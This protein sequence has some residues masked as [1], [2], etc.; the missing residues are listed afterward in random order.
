[1]ISAHYLKDS[2]KMAYLIEQKRRATGLFLAYCPFFVSFL[3][4]RLIRCQFQGDFIN[5]E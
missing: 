2:H 1:M 5:V 3:F 4:L